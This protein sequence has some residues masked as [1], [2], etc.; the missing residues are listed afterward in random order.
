MSTTPTAIAA[1]TPDAGIAPVLL[2]PPRVSDAPGRGILPNV[3]RHTAAAPHLYALDAQP[4]EQVSELLQRQYLSGS[5]VTFVKWI[6]RKGAVVPLHHHGNEQI[7]WITEG[8]AEVYSQGRKYLMN[9]GDIMIIPPNVPHEFV[10]T[11]DTID[12]DIFAPARQDWLD[13]TA[14]YYSK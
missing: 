10:F 7:T 13:G 5:N 11:E 9:A 4:V 12:I 6:A 3:S 14:S 2:S 1:A 8:A